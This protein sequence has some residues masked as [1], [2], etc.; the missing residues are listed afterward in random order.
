MKKQAWIV[1]AFLLVLLVSAM[2]GRTEQSQRSGASPEAGRSEPGG[3]VA[4]AQLPG[5]GA[6]RTTAQQPETGDAQT[7]AQAPEGAA[8][9]GSDRSDRRAV[10]QTQTDYGGAAGEEN[11]PTE[12]DRALQDRLTGARKLFPALEGEP[13]DY[14]DEAH[15]LVIPEIVREVDTIYVYGTTHAEGD[16]TAVI[17]A[18]DAVMQTIAREEYFRNCGIFE[19]STNVFVPYYRQSSPAAVKGKTLHEREEVYK[20]VSRTDLF[21]AL[22]YYFLQENGGRPYILA[23][24]GQG[25]SLLK[26]VLE[27]YMKKHPEYYDR[28]VAAY[29]V[30]T[31]VTDRDL[32]AWPHLKFAQGEEDTGV[33]VSWNTRRAGD[34]GTTIVPSGENALVINPLSWERRGAYASLD[35]NPASRLKDPAAGRYRI[36]RPG[37][38]DAVA[39]MQ[40]GVV[41]T[42]PMLPFPLDEAGAEDALF[43]AGNYHDEDYAFYYGSVRDNVKKRIRSFLLSRSE[44]AGMKR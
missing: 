22:D 35:R 11:S 21:G 32:E 31:V 34:P 25:S 9:V 1:G 30:G 13:L 23:G 40:Q 43:G 18:D 8:A 3:T 17:P 33:I 15:W 38:A 7:I 26:L 36:L 42:T 2:Q 14:T 27:K 20:G 6:P 29:L 37:V 39:D 44:K 5:S 24:H 10:T 16:R 28:M 12:A 4:T 41:W 19:E